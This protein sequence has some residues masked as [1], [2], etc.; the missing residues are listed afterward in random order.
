MKRSLK[1]VMQMKDWVLLAALVVAIV[2]LVLLITPKEETIDTVTVIPPPSQIDIAETDL[3]AS[4]LSS[5][6]MMALPETPV[7]MPDAKLVAWFNEKLGRT[8]GSITQKNI[9]EV[10]N[11]LPDYSSTGSKLNDIT[12]GEPKE[13]AAK[14]LDLSGRQITNLTG[15]EVLGQLSGTKIAINLNTNAVTDIAPLGIPN[16]VYLNANVNQIKDIAPL[17]K[18]TELLELYV[19]N[20]QIADITVLAGLAKLHS[21]GVANNQ[22]TSADALKNHY[23]VNLDLS[24]NR[25]G[26]LRMAQYIASPSTYPLPTTLGI[27]NNY[28]NVLDPNDLSLGLRSITTTKYFPQYKM[29]MYDAAGML[30]PVNVEIGSGPTQFRLLRRATN[31]G[32]TFG[33]PELIPNAQI[34]PAYPIDAKGVEEK[35]KVDFTFDPLTGILTAEPKSYGKQ[36]VSFYLWGIDASFTRVTIEFNVMMNK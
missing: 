18:S 10:V 13:V 4:A 27:A 7:N 6:S 33:M 26:A 24:G 28:I 25:L 19:N 20:N 29:D 11:G 36:I 21:F 1:E 22:V 12:S 31:D 3:E 8:S 30:I 32:V 34:L 17:V 14:L 16:L 9:E 5:Q 23:M 15:L 2:A 35:H